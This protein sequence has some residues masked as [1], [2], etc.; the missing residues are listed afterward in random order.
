MRQFL[1]VALLALLADGLGCRL[2]L[3]A[4]PRPAVGPRRAAAPLYRRRSPSPLALFGLGA[5]GKKTADAE[6]DQRLL[7]ALFGESAAETEVAPKDPTVTSHLQLDYEADGSTTQLRFAY[8]DEQECI[9]CTYC[10]SVAR[11]TFTMEEHGGRARVYAHGQDDPD[12]VMEAI[13]CCPVNCI[14]FVDHEDLVIL[15]SERDGLNGEEG[16]T[17][18]F[19]QAGYRHGENAGLQRQGP[20]KAKIGQKSGSIMCCNNCPSK[21]CK[22]C[23]MYGVGL[24][25]V[26]QA[27]MEEREAK[28]RASGDYFTEKADKDAAE[29]VNAIFDECVVDPPPPL[30][31]ESLECLEDRGVAGM[32]ADAGVDAADADDAPATEGDVWDALFADEPAMVMDDDD[33]P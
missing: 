17:I 32:A 29:K 28:K 26:Y 30:T 18:H 11:N 1:L 14:S 20:S 12:T 24:N 10:A 31:D 19:M 4:A 15:E 9:G 23:P 21:G 5:D 3:D 7:D 8:V 6:S 33:V 13:D 27:R 25:P 16:Q 2:A 22:D